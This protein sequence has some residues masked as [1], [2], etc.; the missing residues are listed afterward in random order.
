M[1]R[2]AIFTIAFCLIA[3]FHA[4]CTNID[5]WQIQGWCYHRA[6]NSAYIAQSRGYEVRILDFETDT[7]GIHHW[8]AQA[9]IDGSWYFLTDGWPVVRVGKPDTYR[10][11]IKVWSLK[12]AWKH[13]LE[14]IK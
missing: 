7:K 5:R 3:I 14:F 11:H 2:I 8:Q 4:G 13:Q 9:L 12:E 6:L 1:R 10:E